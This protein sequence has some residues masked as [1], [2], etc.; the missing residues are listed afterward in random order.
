LPAEPAY[1]LARWKNVGLALGFYTF[2]RKFPERAK[3]LLVA[4]AAKHLR[5]SSD[6][7][8]HFTPTYKPWDQRLC[9]VPDADLFASI[10]RGRASVVTD[11]I[12]TFTETGIRLASG[13]ELPADVIVSATGLKLKLL[14]GTAIEVDGKTADLS[15]SLVYKGMMFSDVPNMALAMGYTNASW[16][17]K[18]DLTAKYVCRLINYMDR[19]GYTHCVP[20]RRGPVEERPLINFT[21]GYVKRAGDH[22]P[23]QGA[24]APWR[25]YQNY[26]LDLVALRHSRLDD[27]VV[28]FSTA[29]RSPT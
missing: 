26:I 9:L 13:E 20:R 14:G 28:E 4:E 1:A 6:V 18:C 7:A 23:R 2:C 5:G 11:R 19:H 29:G 25:L 15:E 21:S 16:T 12:D 3:A 27:P 24:V 8:A 22:L 10:R 17:L